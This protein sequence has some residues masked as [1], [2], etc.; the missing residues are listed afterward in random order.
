MGQM[1]AERS[2]KREIKKYSLLVGL[3]AGFGFAFGS[4]GINSISLASNHGMYPFSKFLVGV[5]ACC[6]VGLLAGWFTWRV[7]SL[8]LNILI[9]V[10]AAVLLN[11]LA[12]FVTFPVQYR[13]IGWLNPTAQSLIQ[14]PLE[15]GVTTRATLV[16]IMMIVAGGI[17]GLLAN[18]FVDEAVTSVPFRR[19]LALLVWMA[20]FIG[21]G[22]LGD[23][24]NQKPMREAVTVVNQAIQFTLQH[25]GEELDPEIQTRMGMRGLRS[26]SDYLHTDYRLLPAQYDQMM[27]FIRVLVKFGD[28]YAVCSVINNSMGTCFLETQ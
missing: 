23:S 21:I 26:V 6:L 18:N 7:K 2:S 19:W 13:I 8:L 22:V 4:W 16:L 27:V 14:Y 15:Y 17:A 9:W 10:F 28:T 1:T 12:L 24:L 5:L 3:L 25:E 20:A 11:R